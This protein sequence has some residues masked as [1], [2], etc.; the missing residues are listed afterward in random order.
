MAF[1]NQSDC[2]PE[3]SHREANGQVMRTIEVAH[4]AIDLHS[5]VHDRHGSQISA[6][7]ALTVRITNSVASAV[8]HLG[9]VY[10]ADS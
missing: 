9:H 3:I 4:R 1:L 6:G 2:G 10:E 5:S 8:N 7:S